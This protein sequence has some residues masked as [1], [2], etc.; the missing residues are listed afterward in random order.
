MD[1]LKNLTDKIGNTAKQVKEGVV[2]V[3]K[4]IYEKGEDL[5]NAMFPLLSP[6]P[7][8]DTR[9][10]DVLK[11]LFGIGKDEEET[12]ITKP[13][14][15]TETSVSTP[16]TTPD[17]KT[18]Q[19]PVPEPVPMP[20]PTPVIDITPSGETKMYGRN[21]GIKRYKVEDNVYSAITNAANEFQIPSAI[22]FDIAL[23]E[24]SL[25]PSVVNTRPEAVDSE[26]NPIN[27]TGLFQFTDDTWND[28]LNMYNN[29]P[30]MSLHLPTTDR[31]D[32]YTNALAAAYLIKMGQL[33]KWADSKD[34]GRN[35]WGPFWPDEELIKLGFYDQTMAYKE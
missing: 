32:P 12:S 28:I 24:S 18:P 21:P 9:V 14:Q 25:N 23:K 5:G 33:G 19:V 10:K 3:G 35:P 30:G 2:N 6:V 7:K 20:T 27:P 34:K 1:W 13:V 29:K 15:P 22:L 16:L 26:G 4:K 11:V 17:I 31:K 8:E